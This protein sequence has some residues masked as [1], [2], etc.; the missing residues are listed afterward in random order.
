[1]HFLGSTPALP[2]PGRIGTEQWLGL[3][4]VAQGRPPH[5]ANPHQRVPGANG[6]AG[7]A[8][9]QRIRPSDCAGLVQF[10]SDFAEAIKSNKQVISERADSALAMVSTSSGRVSVCFRMSSNETSSS[11]MSRLEVVIICNWAA[12]QTMLSNFQ[13]VPVE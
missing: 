3:A 6:N 12:C 2:Q 4:D 11:A 8:P 7:N 13:F 9:S 5:A 10:L 1:M